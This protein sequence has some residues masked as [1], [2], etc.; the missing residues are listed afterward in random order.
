MEPVEV[1]RGI[2]QLKLPL[3]RGGLRFT[4]T[5]LLSE[6]LVDAGEDSREA[7]SSLE[8]QLASL[9]LEVSD[10]KHLIITHLH[11]D[12]IGLV[13]FIRSTSG[14]KIYGHEEA[15]K[16]S[17]A[18]DGVEEARDQALDHLGGGLFFGIFGVLEGG[19]RGLRPIIRI[20]RKVRD[21]DLIPLEGS[22]LEVFWT[23]GHSRE[24]ICLLET[25][26]GILFTGD[27]ILP[28]IT[29]HIGLRKLDGSDPLRDYLGSLK[30]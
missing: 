17:S 16:I 27:H 15:S 11:R 18:P 28:S 8:R 26:R 29:P 13:N 9:G 6:T 10:L 19:L 24:H 3:R 12:H 30:R 7:R 21:G 1:E 4:N 14:V 22:T 25:E 5:Y 23:P 20:D 2:W